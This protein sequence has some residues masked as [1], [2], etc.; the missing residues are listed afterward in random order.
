MLYRAWYKLVKQTDNLPAAA[1]RALFRWAG[2]LVLLGGI[3]LGQD[4]K[5]SDPNK[6][7]AAFIRNFA[8]YVTWP[9]NAFGDDHSPW[10]VGIL[11]DDS[12]GELVEKMF[13]GRVEQ[14]R[15]FKVFRADK[16]DELTQ[17]QIVFIA[18]KDP[19]KRRAALNALK[20]LPVLTVGDTPEFLEEGGIIRFQVKDRVEMSINL[21]Q[22]RAVSLNIPSKM[23]EVTVEVVENGTTRKLR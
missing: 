10:S 16:L 23:L 5:T 2:W 18:F 3:T 7:M 1:E 8:H 15:S 4:L 11:G 17:C 19:V 14:G 6:V 22:S 21:D 13:A 20:N 12:F 9:T